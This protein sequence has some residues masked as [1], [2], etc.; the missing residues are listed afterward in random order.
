MW[1]YLIVKVL[2]KKS[3][4]GFLPGALL[5]IETQKNFRIRESPNRVSVSHLLNEWNRPETR[6]QKSKHTG[7]A[8]QFCWSFSCQTGMCFPAPSPHETKPQKSPLLSVP[9]FDMKALAKA[10]GTPSS[11]SSS[12]RRKSLCRDFSCGRIHRDRKSSFL[13]WMRPNFMPV[14]S[15]A[16]CLGTILNSDQNIRIPSI[17]GPVSC[18]LKWCKPFPLS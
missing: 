12:H 3:E 11:G 5:Q 13:H 1:F 6:E 7:R 15:Y 14:E 4:I 9:L 18:I 2:L 8:L 16:E 10:K 17:I